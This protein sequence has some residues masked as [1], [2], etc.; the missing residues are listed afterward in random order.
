MPRVRGAQRLT[1]LLSHRAS[2][3]K[4]LRSEYLSLISLAQRVLAV[5]RR[6][7]SKMNW[8]PAAIQG[9]IKTWES[10]WG[11]VFVGP[12]IFALITDFVGLRMLFLT[13]YEVADAQEIIE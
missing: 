3:E 12:K 7:L 8:Q 13:I 10:L 5:G 11:G 2:L 9:R 4:K 1:R 6:K